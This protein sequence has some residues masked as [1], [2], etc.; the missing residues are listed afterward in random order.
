[1]VKEA[2]S[3]FWDMGSLL[4]FQAAA[5]PLGIVYTSTIAQFRAA[6]VRISGDIFKRD[7]VYLLHLRQLVGHRS[8]KIRQR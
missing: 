8:I 5:L 3:A 1:M 2:K 7:A 4:L 6:T